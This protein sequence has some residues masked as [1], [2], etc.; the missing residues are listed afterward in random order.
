MRKARKKRKKNK[1]A[2]LKLQGCKEETKQ[3]DNKMEA[4]FRR[5]GV[6]PRE[7]SKVRTAAAWMYNDGQF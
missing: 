7:G 1:S 3:V 2:Y 5:E 4:K 6:K